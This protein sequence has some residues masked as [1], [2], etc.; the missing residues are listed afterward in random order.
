MPKLCQL[1]AGRRSRKPIE[2]GYARLAGTTVLAIVSPTISFLAGFPATFGKEHDRCTSGA[3][4]SGYFR[5]LKCCRA[6]CRGLGHAVA[7][8]GIDRTNRCAAIRGWL[9]PD[10]RF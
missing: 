5:V 1:G 6:P 10:G 4:F 9:L 3:D 7:G 8:D 2:P